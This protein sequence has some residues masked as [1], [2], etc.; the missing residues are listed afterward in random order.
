M[1][2]KWNLSPS[3][4]K[5]TAPT[6]SH[7]CTRC[8]VEAVV[9]VQGEFEATRGFISAPPRQVGSCEEEIARQVMES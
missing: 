2:H 8:G 1:P 5:I 4:G 6:N 9:T 7:I 3:D